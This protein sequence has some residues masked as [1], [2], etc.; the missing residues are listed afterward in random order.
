MARTITRSVGAW[1]R[2][3]KNMPSDV[4]TV[5]QLLQIVASEGNAA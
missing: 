1:E 4:K 5:Q 3:P 2:G